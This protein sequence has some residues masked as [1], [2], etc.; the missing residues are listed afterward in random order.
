MALRPLWVV[1][2]I[3]KLDLRMAVY[4]ADA[5]KTGFYT[6]DADHC[7]GHLQQ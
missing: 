1:A 7:A 2:S 6:T 3:N 5:R 4:N